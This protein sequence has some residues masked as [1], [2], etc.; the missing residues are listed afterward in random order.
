[1]LHGTGGYPRNLLAEERALKHVVK[2][3]AISPDFHATNQ[4]TAAPKERALPP[5]QVSSG[6]RYKAVVVVFLEGGADSFN[7]VVPHSGCK[8]PTTTADDPSFQPRKLVGG[9]SC[10]TTEGCLSVKAKPLC[11]KYADELGVPYENTQLGFSTRKRSVHERAPKPRAS[12]G[13]FF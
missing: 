3:L 5:A 10:L 11:Q 8:R 6:R 12:V 1:M 9:A 7:M 13:S 2:L 4:H